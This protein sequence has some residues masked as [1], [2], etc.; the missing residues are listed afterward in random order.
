MKEAAALSLSDLPDALIRHVLTFIPDAVT[1]C[2]LQATC[3]DFFHAVQ[4]NQT[5]WE[6][7]HRCRWTFSSSSSSSA[8]PLLIHKAEYQRRHEVDRQA[9]KQMQF[10]ISRR[11]QCQHDDNNND[12]GDDLLSVKALRLLMATGRE[13]IDVAWKVHDDIVDEQDDAIKQRRLM[14]SLILLLQR[15]CVYED[16]L[17]LRKNQTCPEHDRLEGYAVWSSLLFANTSFRNFEQQAQLIRQ[18]L[19]E[20]ADNIKRRFAMENV[21][22]IEQKIKILNHVLLEEEGAFVG[23]RENYYDHHN[24]LLS[25]C[26]ERRKGIPLTLAILY[27]IIGHR[28]GIDV[29]NIIGLPGHIVVGFENHTNTYIDLFNQGR[30][31]DHDAIVSIVNSYGFAFQPEFLQAMSPE[32]VVKRVSNNLANCFISFVVDDIQTRV[33]LL[34]MAHSM[35]RLLYNP[36]SHLLETCLAELCQIWILE[37]L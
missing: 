28:V 31:L 29:V 5:L 12:D 35:K 24:S 16:M 15:V 11:R 13:A 23:N 4:D 25:S 27:K 21:S 10:L 9:K 36:S 26:L 2:R 37:D 34:F 19:D 7:L 20:I 18:Q 22:A 14:Q 33:Q 30:I 8:S 3:R 32:E 6:G 17:T 1:L